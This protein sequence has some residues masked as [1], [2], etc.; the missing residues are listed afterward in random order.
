[1]D[2]VSFVSAC[3]IV[4]TLLSQY[5][6]VHNISVADAIEQICKLF[7]SHPEYEYA[8][9]ETVAFISPLVIDL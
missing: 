1:M 2:M 9:R 6:Q 3:T 8:C 5:S 7:A 4:V